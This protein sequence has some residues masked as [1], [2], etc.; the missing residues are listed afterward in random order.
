MGR[1]ACVPFGGGAHMCLGQHFA[2]MQGRAVLRA[3]V[4]R[5]R[6]RLAASGQDARMSFAPI[7]HPPGGLQVEMGP[8]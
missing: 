1:R 5:A 8:A 7:A 2:M 3:L 6:W 4:H